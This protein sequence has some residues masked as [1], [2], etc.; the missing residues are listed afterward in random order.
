MAAQRPAALAGR[1]PPRARH[2]RHGR[3]RP[4]L[5]RGARRP[6]GG[7]PRHARL[8]PLL[9][10][11]GSGN[12]VAFFEYAGASSPFAKPAGVPDP[13]AVQFDH[14]SLNLADE[15][16]LRVAAAR[17]K[18][19]GCEVT[20]VVDHGFMRSIYFTDP[21]ASPS[22]RRGGSPTPPAGPPTTATADLFADADPVPAVR[23]AVADRCAGVDAGRPSSSTIRTTADPAEPGRRPAAG[24]AAEPEITSRKVSGGLRPARSRSVPTGQRDRRPSGCAAAAGPAWSP[25]PAASP[26]TWPARG[27]M[28]RGS[29]RPAVT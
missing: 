28:T 1:Q 14:L 20:D 2:G 15:Q 13:R 29:L 23:G 10:R 16:A 18:E 8:P 6:A 22:R 11:G 19:H 5:P 17:L 27:S 24:D 3:D 25:W 26:P 21:T 9:L 12:T 4:L 7:H